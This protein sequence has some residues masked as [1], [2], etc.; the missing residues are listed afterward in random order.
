VSCLIQKTINLLAGLLGIA[1]FLHVA[2]NL[3]LFDDDPPALPP[4]P[5]ANQIY[6]ELKDPLSAFLVDLRELQARVNSRGEG[7]VKFANAGM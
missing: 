7:L 4:E 6:V 2:E 1:R 5:L 3:R